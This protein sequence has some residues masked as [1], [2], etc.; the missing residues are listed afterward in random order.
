LTADGKKED[1]CKKCAAEEKA[2]MER[3]I[4]VSNE[5]PRDGNWMDKWGA[6]K[7]C[8]GEIPDG[9]MENCDIYKMELKIRTLERELAACKAS[10]AKLRSALSRICELDEWNESSITE[11]CEIASEALSK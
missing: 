9:H 11:A 2:A 4:K 7:V 5:T 10:E 1:V 8:D 6:C 3:T